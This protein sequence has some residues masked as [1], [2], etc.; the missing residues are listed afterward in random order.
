MNVTN[1]DMTKSQLNDLLA[2]LIDQRKYAQGKESE[3]VEYFR[4]YQDGFTHAITT[5]NSQY[6]S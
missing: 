5:I 2:Q 4:G 1:N 6:I 3:D